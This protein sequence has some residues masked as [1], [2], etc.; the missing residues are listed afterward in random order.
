M[1]TSTP[2]IATE[3]SYLSPLIPFGPSSTPSDAALHLI[4]P[5]TLSKLR[6]LGPL[7]VRDMRTS[8][9]TLQIISHIPIENATPQTCQKIND[10]MYS[11][12]V[13]SP[14]RFQALAMLPCGRGVGKEAGRELARCVSKYRFVGGVMGVKRGGSEGSVD[15]EAGSLDDKEWEELWAVAERYKVPIALRTVFPSREKIPEFAGAYPESLIGPLLTNFHAHHTTSPLLILRLYLSGVFD[16]HPN[17]HLILSQSG[18]SIPSLLPRILALDS[19]LLPP[20]PVRSFLDVWQH[21]FYVTTADVLDLQSMRLLLEQIPLDRVLFATGYP[22]EERGRELMKDLRESSIV[23]KEEWE[24]IAFGNAEW[25]FGVK[26]GS[27]VG[28]DGKGVARW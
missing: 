5:A 19:S 3:E 16:R 7:R 26:I 24:R 17:L 28:K 18:H 1:S 25:L 15:G 2:F 20:K 4:P 14:D 6:T 10:A 22:W 11:Q 27:G 21:N 9:I 12:I 23:S 8:S 13:M